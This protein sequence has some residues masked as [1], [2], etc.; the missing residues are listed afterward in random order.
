[1]V[2]LTIGHKATV[3]SGFLQ[4]LIPRFLQATIYPPTRRKNEHLNELCDDTVDSSMDRGFVAKRVSQY[5]MEGLIGN[6]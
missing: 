2:W 3:T 6:R 4:F 1:M 5:T